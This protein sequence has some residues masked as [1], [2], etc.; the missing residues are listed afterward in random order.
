MY[1]V[2]VSGVLWSSF[3]RHWVFTDTSVCFLFY[4]PHSFSRHIQGRHPAEVW[5]LSQHQL[6]PLLFRINTSIMPLLI[7]YNLLPPADSSIPLPCQTEAWGMPY[8]ED[9]PRAR[10]CH[11]WQSAPVLHVCVNMWSRLALHNLTLLCVA[12]GATCTHTR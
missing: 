6:R 3:G 7:F 9:A 8:P 4:K 5:T 11:I 10:S 12:G 2:R 1:I